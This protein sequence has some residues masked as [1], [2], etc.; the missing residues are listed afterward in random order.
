MLILLISIILLIDWEEGI[1]YLSEIDIFFSS[2]V[3]FT[4]IVK[5]PL[6]F[7]FNLIAKGN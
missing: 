3:S 7:S 5:V 4:F 6:V 2:V 1:K